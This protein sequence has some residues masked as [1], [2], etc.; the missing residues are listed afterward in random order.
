M[1]PQVETSA[2]SS[3]SY[4]KLSILYKLSASYVCKAY[5]KQWGFVSR[6]GSCP[7]LGQWKFN[8]SNT[9]GC[10]SCTVCCGPS[11]SSLPVSMGTAL[12]VDSRL[13]PSITWMLLP[14]HRPRETSVSTRS[15]WTCKP[16]GNF[17]EYS[18]LLCVCVYM[19][20]CVVCECLHAHV[21]GVYCDTFIYVCWPEVSDRCLSLSF[22]T[23]FL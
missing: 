16:R 21:C 1:T 6:L 2:S 3:V 17:L 13:S 14:T 10:C 7:C 15:H 20:L 23:L 22:S 9:W 8:R 5:I 4:P 11:S 18:P 12:P 19:F